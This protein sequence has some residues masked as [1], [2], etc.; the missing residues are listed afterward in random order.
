MVNFDQ[1]NSLFNDCEG[2]LTE[3]SSADEAVLT[4]GG[5][6]GRGGSGSGSGSGRRRRRGS[7]SSGGSSSRGGHGGGCRPCGGYGYCFD[8]D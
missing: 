5:K 6:H 7:S 2:F 4:G 3:L 8:D 1:G